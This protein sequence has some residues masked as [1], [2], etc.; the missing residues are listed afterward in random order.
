MQSSSKVP[1]SSETITSDPSDSVEDVIEKLRKV[2]GH[3]SSSLCFVVNKATEWRDR[4]R[5]ATT[6]HA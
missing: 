5:H 4:S 2:S 3:F 1:S 6:L